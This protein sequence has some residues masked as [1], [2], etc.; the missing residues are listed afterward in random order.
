MHLQ[1][2]PFL[3]SRRSGKR[4][5]P[6]SRRKLSRRLPSCKPL[7]LNGKAKSHPPSRSHPAGNDGIEVLEITESEPE[8]ALELIE[9]IATTPPVAALKNAVKAAGPILPPLAGSPNAVAPLSSISSQL[10][11]PNAVIDKGNTAALS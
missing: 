9:E 11:S 2:P 7:P 6:P 1:R 5:N 10:P 3:K 8:Q 4:S